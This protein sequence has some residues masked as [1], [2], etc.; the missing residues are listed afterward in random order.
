MRLAVVVRGYVPQKDLITAYQIRFKDYVEACFN[1]TAVDQIYFAVDPKRDV[2]NTVDFLSTLPIPTGKTLTVIPVS[3]WGRYVE[4][5]TALVSRAATDGYEAVLSANLGHRPTDTNIAELMHHLDQDTLVVGAWL[6]VFH[7]ELP[8]GEYEM[9]GGTTPSDAFM[10]VR[11]QKL[12]L[13]GFL[14]VGSCL[15]TA[16]F[17]KISRA[18]GAW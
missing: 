7:E 10:V 16:C 12:A 1:C 8:P 15:R 11:V 14:A 9:N 3:P 13:F 4:P 18:V 2:G 6:H 5:L 17:A